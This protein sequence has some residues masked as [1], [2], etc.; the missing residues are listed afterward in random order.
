MNLVITIP[1][2]DFTSLGKTEAQARLDLAVFFYKEWR[3]PPG[4]C[5]KFA[6]IPKV[7]FLDELGKRN[8]PVHYDLTALEQDVENWANFKLNHGRHK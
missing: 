5:A 4:R 3:M 7:V 6:G 1:E 8:I 2:P